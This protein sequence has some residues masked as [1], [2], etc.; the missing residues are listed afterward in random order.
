MKSIQGAN[1]PR[2]I[3]A[4]LLCLAFSVSVP[5]Q[6]ANPTADVYV[7]DQGIMRWSANEEEV[8]G[9]GVNYA[10]P[11]AH[12]YR[13][14]KRMGID[15][16]KAIDNDIYHFTRLGFDLY[17]IHV[18]DTEISDTLGNLIENEHLETFDYLL[19]QLKDRSINFVLTPIAFWG[20]GWPEPD[21][22]TPGF[23]HKYGKA[24]C[25]TN[26]EA[27]LAQQNYLYQFL[28][29]VNP[30]TGVA[31]K[32][33]PN[34]IAFE[35]CNEP[36]HKGEASEVTGFVKGMVDAMQRTG[37]K[38]PIF[39]NM[40]H[41][42]HF[43]EAYFKG[44]VQGGTF[45]WYPTNLLYGKELSGNLL[46]NVDNYDIPYEPVIKKYHGA[47]L[48]YEFDAADVGRSYIYPAMARSLRTAGMQIAT[49]FGYEPTFLGAVNTDYSTHFMNLAYTPQKALALKI[50]SAV[51]HE[52][53]LYQEFGA[54]PQNTA[55]GNF[56]V[57]YQ[58]DLAVYNAEARFFYTNTN[59]EHP[60]SEQQLK[61]IAGYGNSILVEYDGTGA[62]FLDKLESGVWRLEVM[63]DAIVVDNPYARKNSPDKTVA[64]INWTERAMKLKLSD[65]GKAFTA[66]AIN[67]GNNYSPKVKNAAFQV[68]PGTYLLTA[69][70][71]QHRYTPE[72]KFGKG[73]LKDFYAPETNVDRPWLKH[74]PAPEASAGQPLLLQAQY[75]GP[76]APKKI[77]IAGN[78][79]DYW[80]NEEM[81]AIGAYQYTVSLPAE[82]L[83]P[84]FLNYNIV[85]EVAK[86]QFV[87]YPSE[88]GKH[89]WDWDYYGSQAY[90]TSIVPGENPILLFDAAKDARFLVKKWPKLDRLVPTEKSGE[91]AYLI[92]V[93]KLFTPSVE[94]LDAAPVYDYSFKHFLLDKIEGRRSDLASKDHLVVRGYSLNDKPCT[95][96]VA[97]VLDDGASYGN[98][99]ELQPEKKEYRLPL[100]SLAPLKTVALPRPYP[101][102]LPYYFSH[103]IKAP[104][105]IHRMESLQFSIGPGL[106]EDQRKGQHGIAIIGI[107]LE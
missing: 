97:F 60:R 99:I 88:I 98:I 67:D 74:E 16:K 18:W 54:Y 41:A 101:D 70:G 5:A 96:Q 1:W 29:H 72:S 45:Q 103:D 83:Q 46:P 68:M 64:V 44:G 15:P 2:G 65:L 6:K 61:E 47:K 106:P 20:N 27:I 30:Y 35:I 78:L 17:R 56:R 81:E 75:V 104:F 26:E 32:D 95:L 69:E 42:V 22:N 59:D 36:H 13:S 38:K 8:K 9:F 62:Y 43:T 100:K 105:D 91:A 84:G 21:E 92:H 76:Q 3:L 94:N 71:K 58:Q 24:G 4:S 25:L 63:P 19:K 33:E 10:V 39:Y 93:E 50:C 34:I 57:D 7:D 51:F 52:I 66:Q 80:F 85:I 90:Q 102:F 77:L 23:S 40:S 89:L 49:H 86:N 48:V 107:T 37:T 12:A 31:Y 14:A 11:F 73:Q 82:V 79:G 87:T 55:F 53:P 28:N